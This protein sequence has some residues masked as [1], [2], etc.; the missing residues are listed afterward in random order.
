MR[1]FVLSVLTLAALCNQTLI[2]AASIRI[3]VDKP[4]HQ[5]S[6]N[7]WGIFF[8]DINCSA[9]GGVYGELVRNRSFEDSDQPEHW[10]LVTHGDAVAHFLLATNSPSAVDSA[11]ARNG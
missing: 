1:A 6:S 2:G 3:Q 4:G 9:D 10:S 7:L 11:Q 8:E 5:I